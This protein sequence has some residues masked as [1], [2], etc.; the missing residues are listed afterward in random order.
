MSEPENRGAEEPR[1]CS[2]CESAPALVYVGLADPDATQYPMCPPCAL[3]WKVA[4]MATLCG[5]E[6]LAESLLNTR[7]PKKKR[8]RKAVGSYEDRG[9]DR[10]DHA[11]RP[12]CG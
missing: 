1:I 8:S 12:P 6:E 3:V 10:G 9:A 5:D 4:A 7:R 2:L 11:G